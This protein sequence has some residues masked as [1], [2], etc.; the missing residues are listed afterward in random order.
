M[1]GLDP[2]GLRVWSA[3]LRAVAEEMQAALVRSAFSVTIKERRDCSTAIFDAR[4]NM[5][6]QADSIPVHLGAMPEAVQAVMTAGALPGEAWIVNDPFT[7][8]THLPDLTIVSPIA[9]EGSVVAHAVTRAHHA[10]VG[11]MTA[12]SMPAGA[13]ELLQEGLVIPPVRLA[14]AHGFDRSVMA[15]IAANSRTPEER[16]GDIAAQLAAHELAW[17]RVGEMAAAR[18]G[19]SAIVH[20]MQA[21][22]A[23]AERRTRA[24]IADM[25]DGEW[26]HQEALEGDGVT[27]EDIIIRVAV[28]VTEHDVHGHAEVVHT[29]GAELG[30]AFGIQPKLSLLTP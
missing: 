25:P 7:G 24:A 28:R 27:D 23:Y 18:G 9:V 16:R 30:A 4:G 22:L 14:D 15:I 21:L 3:A 19:G 17:V 11:G 20:A 29:V 8:G 10:D 6:A 26:T 2:I 1:S 5:V 13:R 12:G